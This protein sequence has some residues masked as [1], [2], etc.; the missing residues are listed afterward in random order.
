MMLELSTQTTPS[1]LSVVECRRL[2]LYQS[3]DDVESDDETA[4]VSPP[5]H[6]LSV[7]RRWRL[8]QLREM[9]NW[10][11]NGLWRWVTMWGLASDGEVLP[12]QLGELRTQVER[13]ALHELPGISC[14][15][16]DPIADLISSCR[17]AASMTDSLD[18]RWELW[19][20]L[21]EDHLLGLLRGREL[22][23][24]G[25]LAALVVLYF[26]CLTRLM[27]A[28]LSI[29]VGVDDW[30]PVV[31]GGATR[32]GMRFA[33]DQLRR[34]EQTGR[35][36]GDVAWRVLNDHVLTQHERVAFAKLPDDTFRFRREAGRLRFFDR[37]VEFQRNSSRFPA[38]ST[39]CAELGWM[40]F[41]GEPDHA[42]T[43]E[44]ERI[45]QFG[46]LG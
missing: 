26:F 6:L 1:V 36:I 23:R 3:A 34:D 24:D 17:E 11:L 16:S 39:V 33:L 14:R 12:L 30:R 45:R 32:I 44:G 43:D 22:D 2:V 10:S 42:L 4:T 25:E 18:G 27:S 7:A 20:D 41:I 13:L 15:A 9:F 29:A 38:L 8:S 5:E 40:G 35:S 21:T 28:D 31:E 37:P 19:T 46:D